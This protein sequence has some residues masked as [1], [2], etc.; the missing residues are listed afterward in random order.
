MYFSGNHM[1]FVLP[2]QT[3]F[4]VDQFRWSLIE[5]VVVMEQIEI[6]FRWFQKFM[7]QSR[8]CQLG[9]GDLQTTSDWTPILFPSHPRTK[10]HPHPVLDFVC[11][12]DVCKIWTTFWGRCLVPLTLLQEY[13]I[14]KHRFAN[15]T[16][17]HDYNIM[18]YDTTS[19]EH[20]Q[21]LKVKVPNFRS[22]NSKFESSSEA[23]LQASK[24]LLHRNSITN[25]L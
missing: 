15:E 16:L 22:G 13:D 24:L 25:S 19:P 1:P 6:M 20:R 14:C 7:R 10:E 3:C 4:E 2:I 8:G 9:S 18:W 21:L 12:V 23:K 11:T 17:I 5:L